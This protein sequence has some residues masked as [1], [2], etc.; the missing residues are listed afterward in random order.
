VNTIKEN[1]STKDVKI[2]LAKAS[3]KLVKDRKSNISNFKDYIYSI[4]SYN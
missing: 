1:E 3:S 4:K 2:K